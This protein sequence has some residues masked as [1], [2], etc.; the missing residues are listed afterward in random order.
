ML[1]EDILPLVKKEGD[2]EKKIMDAE[3]IAESAKNRSSETGHTLS[4]S[5]GVIMAKEVKRVGK[6]KEDKDANF[7]RLYKKAAKLL[8]IE[9]PDFHFEQPKNAPSPIPPEEPRNSIVTDQMIEEAEFRSRIPKY[10]PDDS[11]E[12]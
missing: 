5:L 3:E 8:D 2:S 10:Y 6:T 1:I 11:N 12:I 7:K 4:A 9:P